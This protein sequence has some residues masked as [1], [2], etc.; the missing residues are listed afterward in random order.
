MYRACASGSNLYIEAPTGT[1]KTISTI[2]PAVMAV[3][4]G[5]GDKIFYLTAKTITRTVAEQTYGILREG[6]LHYRTVTLTARDKVCILEE[7]NCNPDACP[8]AKGHFDRVNDAVYD[9]IT[10]ETA[11]TRD[12]IVKYAA[13][14][15]VCPFELSLDIS[16]WCDGIICDYNYVFDPNVRLKRFFADGMSGGYIF[17]VDE[18]HNLV[19]RGRSMYSAAVVKED[20]LRHA[21]M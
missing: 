5:H 14:H 1:G 2:Y 8:Y 7:R 10:H 17:L 15:N 13:L 6:G 9:V 19:D 20:S 4:E 12:I 21:N 3:G 18:A 16:L 11:I